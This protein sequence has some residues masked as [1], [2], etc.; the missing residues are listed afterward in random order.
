MRGPSSPVGSFVDHIPG[1]RAVKEYAVSEETLDYIGGLNSSSSLFLSLGSAFIG[2]AGS[3]CI[4]FLTAP[5]DMASTVQV[6]L[7]TVMYMSL[8]LSILFYVLSG[9]YIFKQKGV[10]RKIKSDTIHGGNQT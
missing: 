2:I 6:V 3:F 7:E 4:T 9:S 5:T 1:R 10:I 8:V